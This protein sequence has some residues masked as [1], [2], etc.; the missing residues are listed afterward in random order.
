MILGETETLLARQTGGDD[1]H[2]NFLFFGKKKRKKRTPEE[3]EA[4]KARR[5]EF[6]KDVDRT[7]QGEGMD[8][9]VNNLV[10]ALKKTSSPSSA[11]SD[12][13]VGLEEKDG[14]EQKKKE[15]PTGT[16]IVGGAVVVGIIVYIISG[17][18]KHKQLKVSN[19]QRL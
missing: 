11:A 12:Y 8:Q 16:Y 3:N 4:R 15:I 1:H 18:Q 7:L 19:D 10:G 17:L 13:Q 5:K 6:W 2:D 14:N 9:S